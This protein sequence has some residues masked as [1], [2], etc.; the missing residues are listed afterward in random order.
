MNLGW[1]QEAADQMYSLAN[2]HESLHFSAVLSSST[3]ALSSVAYL[4][5]PSA[6]GATDLVLVRV[7]SPD[8][9][10]DFA[11]VGGILFSLKGLQHN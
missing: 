9:G 2:E 4:D 11:Q 3:S 8:N 5:D 1:T 6:V 10:H 7:S